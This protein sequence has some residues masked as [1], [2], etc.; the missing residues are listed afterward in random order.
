MTILLWH[1][2]IPYGLFVLLVVAFAGID[3][4]HMVKFGTYTFGNYLALTTFL[5]GTVLILWTTG[6]LLASVD[7]SLPITGAMDVGAMFRSGSVGL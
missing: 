1:L 6:W 5:V 2:L 7:W 4:L 3:V